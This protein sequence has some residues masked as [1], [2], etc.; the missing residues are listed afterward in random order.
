MVGM[1][2]NRTR[3]NSSAGGLNIGRARRFKT[4]TWAGFFDTFFVY[5]E[6]GRISPVSG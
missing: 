6:L 4:G 2:P 3:S 5:S 1:S